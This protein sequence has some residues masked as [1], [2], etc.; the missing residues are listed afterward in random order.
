MPEPETN[1]RPAGTPAPVSGRVVVGVDG[2]PHSLRALD[3]AADEAHRR[4]AELRVLCGGTPPRR[5]AVPETDADRERMRQAGKEVADAAAERARAR[6]PGLSVT[7]SGVREPAAEALVRASRE[8]DLTVVGSRGHGGF[9]GLL[10]GSVSLRLAAHAAGPLMVVRGD[11]PEPAGESVGGTVVGLKWAGATEPVEYA[12]AS[13]RRSGSTLW[14]VHSWSRPTL[15]GVSLKLSPKEPSE[16]TRTAERFLAQT[17]EPF[18]ERY[19]EVQV[20]TEQHQGPPAEHLIKLSDGADLVVLG[21]R[22]EH[23]R[24]GLQVGPVVNA[25]LQH[26][27]CSVALVPVTS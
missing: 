3:R 16:E 19:P 17:V 11:V 6:V 13:A 21:V 2:S 26:A 5:T 7:A 14:V 25:V 24:L 23:R 4:G 18:R 22:R 20:C 27:K 10:L 15:P 12:F 1:E 9:R 8:A